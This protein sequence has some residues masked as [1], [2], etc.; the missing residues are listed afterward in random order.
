MVTSEYP[1]ADTIVVSNRDI[2]QFMS[3]CADLGIDYCVY[4]KPVD[5]NFNGTCLVHLSPDDMNLLCVSNENVKPTKL[6]KMR[7]WKI[8]R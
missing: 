8:Y 6:G 5:P 4:A 7:S 2:E 3:L 1:H